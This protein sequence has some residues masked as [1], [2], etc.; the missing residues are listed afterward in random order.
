MRVGC[1]GMKR[2]RYRID[3]LDFSIWEY[4]LATQGASDSLLAIENDLV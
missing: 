3:K 1:N 2:Y 4:V